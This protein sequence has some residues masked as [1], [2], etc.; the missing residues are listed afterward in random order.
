MKRINVPGSGEGENVDDPV[1][2]WQCLKITNNC[3]L[4]ELKFQEAVETA[5]IIKAEYPEEFDE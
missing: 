3:K 4:Q 5:K 1:D 2:C